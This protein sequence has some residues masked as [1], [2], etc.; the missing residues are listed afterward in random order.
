VTLSRAISLRSIASLTVLLC[1]VSAAAAQV[2]L[3]GSV[4]PAGPLAGPA[5]LVPAGAGKT[6]GNNLFHSFSTFNLAKGESATFSGPAN[7]RNVLARVTGGTPSLINGGLRST[8]P[9]ADFYFINP[10]GVIF[11]PDAVLDV[12]NSFTVTTASVIRLAD[13]GA[14]HAADPMQD[15][16]TSAPPAAFGFLTDAPAP[17]LIT[18]EPNGGDPDM[19]LVPAGKALTVVAGDVALA[20]AHL[21]AASGA[22]NIVSAASHGEVVQSDPSQPPDTSQLQALGRVEIA[23]GSLLNAGGA[24]AGSVRVRA[25]ELLMSEAS[26][27][28]SVAGGDQIDPAAPPPSIDLA[29]RRALDLSG[30]SAIRAA[31]QG[32]AS[33]SVMR[34]DAGTI[35]LKGTD[36]GP[37][38]DT[39]IATLTVGTNADAA[40]G[41]D[42]HLTADRLQL[43]N[44]ALV[45]SF[46][47]GPGRAGNIE[48]VAGQV[49][50]A[51]GSFI[52]ATTFANG[53]GGDL[54]LTV[55]DLKLEAA[56][57]T[58]GTFL[59]GESGSLT[60]TARKSIVIDSTA[61]GPAA[62]LASEVGDGAT[63]NGGKI[64]VHA[65]DAEMRLLHGGGFSTLT[66]GSGHGGEIEIDARSIFVSGLRSDG[67]E[68]AIAA[69]SADNTASGAGGG[70]TLRADTIELRD[71]GA[72][73]A[74]TTGSGRGGS[75]SV[76]A[77][78]L[79]S[80]AGAAPVV[81]S[82]SSMLSESGIRTDTIEG[83]GGSIVVRSPVVRV[84]DGGEISARTLGS[85]PGGNVQI[86]AE[87]ITFSGVVVGSFRSGS[88]FANSG[89]FCDTGGQANAGNVVIRA[90]VL[91]LLD[92]G[93]IQGGTSGEG[94]GGAI[95]ILARDRVVLRGSGPL[96]AQDPQKPEELSPAF[97]SLGNGSRGAGRGGDVI[98]TAPSVTLLDGGLIAVQNISSGN[99]GT[100]HL[101]ADDLTLQG[102]A[103]GQG[104]AISAESAGAGKAGDLF[105]RV[106][107]L[108]LLDRGII[109]TNTFAAGQG[110]NIDIAASDGITISGA[111]S[112]GSETIITASAAGTG[113][114][115]SITV[116]TPSLQ[117]VA[118]GAISATTAGPAPGGSVHV[119]A[120]HLVVDGGNVP[121]LTRIGADTVDQRPP[122][123]QN[124]RS[125]DAGNVNIR[126]GSIE[127]LNGGAISAFTDGGSGR[128]GHI[129]VQ[130]DRFLAS[131]LGAEIEMPNTNLRARISPGIQAEAAEKGAGGNVTLQAGRIDLVD[132]GV[133]TVATTGSGRAGSVFI[134]AGDL[135]IDSRGAAFQAVSGL[136][137]GIFAASRALPLIGETAP[138]GDAGSITINAAHAV[139]LRDRGSIAT[140][141]EMSNAGNIDLT[142][143]PTGTGLQMFSS[144]ITSEARA[145]NGGD[146]HIRA[147][148]IVYLLDSQI[149]AFA[150]Q[151][152]ARITIDPRFVILNNSVIN[153]LAGN[154][155]QPVTIV[156]ESL[157]VSTES[158]IL[159][160][161]PN[162]QVDLDI[163]SSLTRLPTSLAGTQAKLAEQCGIRLGRELS[164]FIVTG[165]GGVAAEPDPRFQ[166]AAAP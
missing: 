83:A 66:Q 157:I 45:G 34:I 90:N 53:H 49:S 145:G 12:P 134:S 159:T 7:I 109:S 36:G 55:D 80:I 30:K 23:A 129:N 123:E 126:A 22:V 116:A 44:S 41:P 144:S 106:K 138:T 122:D 162:F 60:L 28:Q 107:R 93:V 156:A 147:P 166:P 127:L 139:T 64:S 152:G 112:G 16:L 140:S 96:V 120:N 92:G 79:L 98:V 73:S 65:K 10:A 97:S 46:S 100:V 87:Q 17:V 142:I 21:A 102:K 108:S 141:A 101:T 146:I 4:G 158:A 94:N 74:T 61:A 82:E 103:F 20:N 43:S 131:G 69:I 99:A 71:A 128:G 58:T 143:A 52:A 67:E 5:Y 3:D 26:V 85:G 29:V 125:G 75:I 148:L 89:V 117:V 48:I 54:S 119:D 132:G 18:G 31:V 111:A 32:A 56:V 95:D 63:G 121:V 124:P 165:R 114:S 11:G 115:G 155:P 68:S 1:A 27:I 40:T 154:T 133:I 57:M 51:S 72:I 59:S 8:L 42:L 14:F 78:K 137:T 9:N 77:A 2:V 164:S 25:G 163:A 160:E 39:Q 37:L 38:Q 110:G 149:T 150:G 70:I 105:L 62:G 33:G 151:S 153:G 84:S 91:E 47:A 161:L 88:A 118:G 35:T 81:G 86:D 6:V 24:T 15:V 76:T 13:G 113:A 19:L 130:A 104:S 50:C 135:N 136:G